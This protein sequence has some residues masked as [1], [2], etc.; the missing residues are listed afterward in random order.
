MD[1]S[2]GAVCVETLKRDWRPELT[3]R[4]ILVTVGCLLI[5]PGPDSA[6]NAEAGRL[7]TE[8]WEGYVRKAGLWARMHAAVPVGM[9]GEVEEARRRGE[10]AGEGRAGPSQSAV[11]KKRR[12]E[13]EQVRASA[14]DV[15]VREDSIQRSPTGQFAA[16]LPPPA[17]ASKAMGLGLG[18]DLPE[19]SSIHIN[20]PPERPTQPPAPARRRKKPTAAEDEQNN[21]QQPATSSFANSLPTPTPGLAR[22]FIHSNP[23]TPRLGR[24]EPKRRRLTPEDERRTDRPARIDAGRDDEPWLNWERRSPFDSPEDARS[25]KRRRVVEEKRWNIVQG[26]LERWNAGD[27]G[28]RIGLERL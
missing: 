17:Q 22:P 20:A 3:L 12:R 1:P 13:R 2:S 23:S 4:D 21:P 9:R 16:P 19:G 11:E 5:F 24:P 7:V 14:E 18:I 10:D 8:D 25:A 15:F 6:L 27:F 28:P 26:D